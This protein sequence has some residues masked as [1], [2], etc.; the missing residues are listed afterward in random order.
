MKAVFLL[1]GT[2]GLLTPIIA[3][4]EATSRTDTAATATIVNT[5]PVET[6]PQPQSIAQTNSAQPL[7]QG[8]QIRFNGQS[9]TAGWSQWQTAQG[10][11]LFISEIALTQLLGIQLFSSDTPNLQPIGWFSGD[12]QPIGQLPVRFIGTERHFDITDFAALMS[13]DLRLQSNQLSLNTL[14][15]TV[16]G[17]R[18]AKRTWGDRLVIDLDG[19]IAY[20]Y[21][22]K[23]NEFSLTLN[24]QTETTIAKSINQ[25]WQ[26]PK[27]IDPDQPKP[28]APITTSEPAAEPPKLGED[29]LDKPIPKPIESSKFKRIQAFKL[30]TSRNRTTLKLGIPI[31]VRPQI[32]TLNNPSR[33]VIDV[34]NP[35]QTSRDINWM[36]G[37]Q[38]RSQVVD[39]FPL[40]WLEIDPKQPELSI[41][42]ILPNQ[43]G[44]NQ[45]AIE[46]PPLSGIA[47]LIQTARQTGAIGAIN[48]GFFNRNNKF[49]LGAIRIN[50]NWRS[51]PILARGVVGWNPRGDFRFDRLIHQAAVLKD[52]ERFELKSFN[53]AYL[54]A[55]IARYN[56]DW[57][58][59]YTSMTDGE[60]IATV[61][62][63][64]IITQK[65]AEKP[66]TI[67]P[68]STGD[69]LL[70]FRSNRTG[71]AKF[72]IGTAV[73]F[74]SKFSP[75]LDNYQHV[76]GGGPLLIQNRQIILDGAS[77]KFSP[78]FVKGL[79]ARSAIAQTSTG[80]ILLVAAQ[81]T[82]DSRGPTLA[83]FAQMLQKLD[84]V[85]ALNL[86]GGSS[87]TLYLG[88]QIIDRAP[89]SSARVHNAI[90][91]FFTPKK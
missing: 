20:Q 28:P 68:I 81:N 78:A 87:T 42:P 53:S 83:A 62:N 19:P 49:P 89:R 63:G 13:W 76:I 57:G 59:N 74:D 7:Q 82:A 70:V 67:V 39:G 66:G 3:R 2:I 84:A 36:D 51:G 80:K 69:E 37:L 17:I 30:D 25:N 29:P 58:L 56:Q 48:G 91:I 90:G 88:G 23:S 14:S 26:Y 33:L 60:V 55:G 46:Q 5:L 10:K 64:Q 65:I 24:A 47:T 27:P 15:A 77:E 61:R 38:W 16:K 22:A 72:P 43:K 32:L 21:T 50:Q 31:A 86:D 6:T 40:N 75:D 4:A 79:A 52:G 11:R 85:N 34:G 54:Q 44:I 18:V 73:K 71:A 8:R 1:A 41:Q 45:P 9:E 12:T 35:V